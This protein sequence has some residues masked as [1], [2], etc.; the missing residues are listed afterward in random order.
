MPGSPSAMPEGGMPPGQ[1]SAGQ[2]AGSLP[3]PVGAEALGR[4]AGV[5]AAR[6]PALFLDYDGTLTP[7]MPRPD[8]A[9]LDPAMRERI[10]RLAA[11]CPVA[12]V[13]GRDLADV[14]AMVG[15]EGLTYAGS[16][17]FDIE[18]PSGPRQ[19]GVEYRPALERAAARL[20][21]SLAGIQ[22]AL[23]EPKRFAVAVHTRAVAPAD[24]AAVEAAV[25]DAAAAEP[26]LRRTGGKEI[27]ELR[28]DLP[29][30]KGRAVL[31]LIEG[32]RLDDR[33]PVYVGDDLTDE[34]A[35]AA[36]EGRGLGIVVGD[37]GGPSR[38]AY[39]LPDIA[40]VGLLLEALARHLEG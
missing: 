36:L 25:A 35:F 34:D 28:P 20:G 21:Q 1:P 10:R 3:E 29:W 5:L 24:K 7:I 33:F 30:D 23:V 6:R 38:A 39:R 11:L 2:S 8:L 16:H 37:H 22:G 27:H 40:S 26:G 19:F 14:R 9:V 17:G 4:V 31:S 15:I 13:S 18:A 32:E 12:V